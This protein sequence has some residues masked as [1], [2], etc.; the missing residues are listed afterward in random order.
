MAN[1]TIKLERDADGRIVKGNGLWIGLIIVAIAAVGMLVVAIRAST[2]RAKAE[3]ELK[4][5]NTKAAQLELRNKELES[6]NKALGE[7]LRKSATASVTV[8]L[9]GDGPAK[10]CQGYGGS[11]VCDGKACLCKSKTETTAVAA[12]SAPAAVN[13]QPLR[14]PGV[15]VVQTGKYY[16]PGSDFK[17]V[18][19]EADTAFAKCGEGLD[20]PLTLCIAEFVSQP[21]KGRNVEYAGLAVAKGGLTSDD[22]EKIARC[23]RQRMP[24]VKQGDQLVPNSSFVASRSLF[25]DECAT[26]A[27]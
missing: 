26:I 13:K 2:K 5:A 7:T 18:K 14:K 20:P 16:L 11:W 6:A 21:G 10:A 24:K 15:F 12:N 4:T 25:K 8:T 23:L 3:T 22:A 19:S 17:T 1:E 27:E 9:D